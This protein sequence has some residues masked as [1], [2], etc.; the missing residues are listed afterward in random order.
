MHTLVATAERLDRETMVPA[1]VSW[2]YGR[3]GFRLQVVINNELEPPIT[4]RAT[5]RPKKKKKK[6]TARFPGV[7]L[8]NLRGPVTR[9]KCSFALQDLSDV[10]ES[11]ELKPAYLSTHV[12]TR[13]WK[14]ANVVVEMQT[15]RP[16]GKLLLLSLDFPLSGTYT[17]LKRH[18]NVGTSYFC[19]PVEI[20]RCLPDHRCPFSVARS[21]C[22]LV[23]D[24][25]NLSEQ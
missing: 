15:P 4:F 2:A 9:R 3:S 14:I 19:H 17:K 20:P 8:L 13:S 6:T 12:Y 24:V 21:M 23:H 5:G 11:T 16:H 1:K 10:L 25:Q 7:I 18:W 22:R